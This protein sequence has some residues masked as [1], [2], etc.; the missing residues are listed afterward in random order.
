M[1]ILSSIAGGLAGALAVT[2]LNEVVKRYDPEAPRLDLLGMSAV[3][4]GFDQAN[5]HIPSRSDQYKYSLIADLIGNTLFFAMAGKGSTRKALSQ[6]SLL[7]LTAGLGAVFTPKPLG[8]DASQT[9]RTTRTQL[10]TVAYYLIGGI[11]AGAVS[12]MVSKERKGIS[13]MARRSPVLL[14]N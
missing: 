11:V 2:L 13:G 3:S 9:N 5:E 6:G 8:L 7:G 12:K 14:P 4:K 10:M 1:K